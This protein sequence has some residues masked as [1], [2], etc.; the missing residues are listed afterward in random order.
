MLIPIYCC[1]CYE[2]KQKTHDLAVIYWPS[3]PSLGIGR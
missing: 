1:Y 3:L 2:V